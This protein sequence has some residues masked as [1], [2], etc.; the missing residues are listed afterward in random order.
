M[1]NDWKGYLAGQAV[2][3][4]VANEMRRK[5]EDFEERSKHEMNVDDL[6]ATVAK[7]LLRKDKEGAW[8]YLNERY[9]DEIV[10]DCQH[11]DDRNFSLETIL[12]KRKEKYA[13][14]YD[15]IGIAMP[16]NLS[17][18]TAD[19]LCQILGVENLYMEDS[20]NEDDPIIPYESKSNNDGC[21][22][23]LIGVLL[24]AAAIIG[25][26]LCFANV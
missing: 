23:T 18:I 20:D 21:S 9:M 8:K 12:I 6:S 10:D 11:Q 25:L 15:R 3:G 5:R 22:K 1:D 24:I 26:M 16:D 4:S 2:G 13:P 7:Y 17:Y 19:E 14:L